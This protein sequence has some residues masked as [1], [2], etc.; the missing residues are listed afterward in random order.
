[1]QTLFSDERVYCIS[2][3]GRGSSPE[4]KNNPDE[5]TRVYEVNDRAYTRLFRYLFSM[6]VRQCIYADTI[7]PYFIS[8]IMFISY[9][10]FSS[11]GLGGVF[12]R[13]CG[14]LIHMSQLLSLI[15]HI[16]FVVYFSSVS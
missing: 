10:V 14:L 1:M 16:L 4:K 2:G 12:F 15:A 5:S 13:T 9:P 8:M 3:K 7:I 11:I 6:A